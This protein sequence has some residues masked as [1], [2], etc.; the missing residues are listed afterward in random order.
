MGSLPLSL[1]SE[2]YRGT[3]SESSKGRRSSQ[4]SELSNGLVCSSVLEEQISLE[5]SYES[6]R[7]TRGTEWNFD[8]FQWISMDF[9]EIRSIPIAFEGFWDGFEA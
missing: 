5:Q 6:L 2:S 9:M 8:G 7:Q 4:C 1:F 3:S